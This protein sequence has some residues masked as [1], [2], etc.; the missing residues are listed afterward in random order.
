MAEEVYVGID[1]SK[2]ELVVA[3]RPTD[4]C[5]T[6]ANDASGIR[7]LVAR[8]RKVDFPIERDPA[9]AWPDFVGWRVNYEPTA[10]TMAYAL[11]LVP[12]IWSGP[13]RRPTPPVTPFRPPPGRA[14]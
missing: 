14:S 13:R 11:D 1:V 9:D 8:L 5:M 4:E 2:A 12:A 10:Y 3:L 6:L 7:Q